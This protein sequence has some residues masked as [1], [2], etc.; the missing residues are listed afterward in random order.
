MLVTSSNYYVIK[1]TLIWIKSTLKEFN[2][3]LDI[4]IKWACNQSV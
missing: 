1:K 4:L 2:I 3:C